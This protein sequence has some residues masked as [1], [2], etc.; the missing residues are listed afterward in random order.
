[1]LEHSQTL[2]LLKEAKAG[3]QHAKEL[4]LIH[5][6]PLLKSIIKRFYNKG[7]EYDDLFQLASMGLVKAINNFDF[8]YNVRFSTYAVPMIMGEIKRFLRDDGYIKVSRSL[9]TLYSKI[10][11]YVEECRKNG[12]NSPHIEEIATYLSVTPEEVVLAMEC[13]RSPVSLYEKSEEGNERS[14]SLIDKIT[15]ND[16][17]DDNVEKIVLKGILSELGER[18]KKIIMLRYF[19]DMTQGQVSK[20]LGVSQVQV[21]RLESKILEKIKKRF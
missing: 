7:V 18:E 5:N 8:S 3:D 1:M 12:Q 11:R 10:Y 14:L 9:K 21:S 17:T 4:L 6:T 19:R 20:I 13:V 2:Q 15:I 16:S